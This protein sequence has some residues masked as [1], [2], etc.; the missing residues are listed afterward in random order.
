MRAARGSSI[1]HKYQMEQLGFQEQEGDERD[2]SLGGQNPVEDKIM[3]SMLQGDFDNL[4]GAG[5]PRKDERNSLV[6]ATTHV[7][8]GILSNHGILPDF[9]NSQKLMNG[10]K[11]YVRAW[12]RREA[13]AFHLQRL[14]AMADVEKEGEDDFE[15]I[16]HFCNSGSTLHTLAK[17]EEKAL[18]YITQKY[19]LQCPSHVLTRGLLQVDLEVALVRQELQVAAAAATAASSTSSSSSVVQ[20]VQARIDEAA[21]EMAS[22]VALRDSSIEEHC[23]SVEGRGWVRAKGGVARPV[24]A[25]PAGGRYKDGLAGGW[26]PS[27]RYS[28]QQRSTSTTPLGMDVGAL[29]MAC[30]LTPLDGFTRW[31]TT[32]LES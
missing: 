8:Y 17:E 2:L 30:L 12:L 9:V 29:A 23:I 32:K 13:A 5:K 4:E 27:A 14:M 25:I 10:H 19:N 7:G 6:D 24:Y 22:H 31:L 3:L 16:A 11:G 28:P 15:W 20:V 18:D 26:S 1:T 21:R